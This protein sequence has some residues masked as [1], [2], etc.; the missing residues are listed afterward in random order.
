MV[1]N[2]FEFLARLGYAARGAVYF[3]L[4]LIALFGAIG[5]I[6]AEPS[7]D[8]AFSA[9][10]GQPFGR[11]LLGLVGVGLVFHVLWRIAQSVF[12]ADR[13]GT[14]AKAWVV[15]A[16]LLISAVVNAGLAFAALSRALALGGGEGGG[17]S[18]V[19]TVL[20]LPFGALLLMAAGLAVL[21]AGLA[22]AWRGVSGG[23]HERIVLIG[24]R[25]DLL[26][27]ICAVGL[28]ARGLLLAIIGGLV[29]YAGFTVSPEQAS[30]TAVALDWIR[31]LPFGGVFYT[32]AAAGLI[33]F[34][35]YN[36]IAARYRRI[37]SP[38][39]APVRAAI[40]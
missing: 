34:A 13:R 26:G 33:A 30:D 32:I 17:S 10:L 8:G 36:G 19:E 18:A 35:L 38:N 5:G 25:R 6:G 2:G 28:V 20:S 29:I 39:M 12:D 16:S 15:R 14:D 4:G 7:T 37:D 31:R 27:A 1:S 24:A 40:S 23:F 22:Q 21:G 11:I 9:L 3:V